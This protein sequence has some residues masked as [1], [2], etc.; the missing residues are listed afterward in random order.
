MK[1]RLS[2]EAARELREI[3][4]YI[5]ERNPAAALKVR[6]DIFATIDLLKRSPLV[7]RRQS[8]RNVRK[9]ITP[10]YSYLVYYRVDEPPKAVT[11]LSIRH[12]ARSRRYRDD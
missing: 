10:K 2:R 8:V 12:G 5:R 11:V 6:A 9:V 7:G 1:L 3:G 4:H